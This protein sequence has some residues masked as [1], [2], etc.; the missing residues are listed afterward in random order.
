[1]SSRVFGVLAVHIPTKFADVEQELG[2]FEEVADDLAFAL[3]RIEDLRNRRDAEQLLQE[4]E[5][6]YRALI[7]Q[8]ADCLI[9]HDLDANIL[10][11]NPWACSTYQYTRDELLRMKVSDLDPDYEEREAR[12][13]WDLVASGNPIIF[14]ARQRKRDGN[15]FSGGSAAFVESNCREND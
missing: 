1:M 10:D 5:E 7:M 15:D 6:K 13:F 9:L 2:L 14:Q 12:G 4:S 8:S 3:G 11:V